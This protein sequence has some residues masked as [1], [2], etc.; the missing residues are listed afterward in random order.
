[1]IAELRAEVLTWVTRL[2]WLQLFFILCLACGVV[3]LL[4]VRKLREHLLNSWTAAEGELAVNELLALMDG[5]EKPLL[6]RYAR[7]KI[8]RNVAMRD[9]L[10]QQIASVSGGERDYLVR[11]YLELGCADEDLRKTRSRL[12]ARRLA[13]TARLSQLS[14]ASLAPVFDRLQWDGNRL[15]GATALLA[16]S[17]LDHELNRP[18]IERLAP[19]L[20]DGR[21]SLVR[22]SLANWCGLFGFEAVFKN[23][24]DSREG[25]LR[26]KALSALL[27]A[28][29]P[30]AG[31]ALMALLRD[32]RL[33]ASLV[34]E[35]LG[36]LREIGDPAAVVL[37]RELF[38][39][40]SEL[41]K[42]RAAEVMLELG[43]EGFRRDL[44]RI[45]SE[46]STGVRRLLRDW[47]QKRTV[48]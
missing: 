29:T 35:T 11:R 16:L 30:E 26:H 31:P 13:G 36:A 44:K 46:R 6:H 2:V 39:H 4:F 8:W 10:L 3:C 25:E 1:M 34:A 5:E 40:P 42:Q 41:V 21:L 14:H 38:G 47:R 43:T 12:W 32:H 37:A 7:W 24:L 48:G 45:K 18:E 9:A 19:L 22:A 27:T 20:E 17:G 28:K 33:P 23:A 15:V